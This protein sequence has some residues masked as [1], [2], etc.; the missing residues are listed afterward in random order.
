MNTNSIIQTTL[1]AIS[2]LLLPVSTHAEIENVPPA[3]FLELVKQNDGIILDVRTPDEVAQGHIAGASVL[4]IYDKDFE[5]KLNLMQKDKPIYVYCRSGGRSSKAAQTMDANGFRS[6]FNLT[7][8]IGAWNDAKLPLEKPKNVSVKKAA[9]LSL[10]DFEKKLAAK[11]V[12]LADFHTEWCMP[13]KQ[14]APVIDSL[15]KKFENQ[16]SIIRVDLDS[17][18]ELGS[19]FEIKGVPVFILFVDGKEQ[20]RHSGTIE[21][22]VLQAKIAS[23]L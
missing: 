12:A 6:I 16:A 23:A 14:M 10:I 9:P 22:D 20:W 15:E 3:E 7:G 4:D 11:S 2:V 19:T 8:G 18:P 17:S 21:A 13:C 5:R 1:I